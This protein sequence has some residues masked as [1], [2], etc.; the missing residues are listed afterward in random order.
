MANN[1]ANGYKRRESCKYT[2][3]NFNFSLANGNTGISRNNNDMSTELMIEKIRKASGLSD[4]TKLRME[5][6][7]RQRVRFY[8][9]WP[10]SNVLQ[11][12]GF[13]LHF[14]TKFRFLT[15]IWISDKKFSF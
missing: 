12:C 11:L 6:G 1:Y 2:T 3:E 5:H 14:W 7:F 15:Q 10:L 13:F 8:P 4:M 9:F